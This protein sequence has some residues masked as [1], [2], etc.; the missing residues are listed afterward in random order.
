ME[1]NRR[2]VIAGDILLQ[3]MEVSACQSDAFLHLGLGRD[4]Q[5]PLAIWPRIFTLAALPHGHKCN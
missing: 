1:R 3:D 4:D 5:K 2:S